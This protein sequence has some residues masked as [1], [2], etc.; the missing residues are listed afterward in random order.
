MGGEREA[1]E[2]LSGVTLARRS[3]AE[4]ESR[5]LSW[6]SAGTYNWGF[7]RSPEP[8]T[9][10]EMTAVDLLALFSGWLEE[11]NAEVSSSENHY[12]KLAPVAMAG[13]ALKNIRSHGA[14][15]SGQRTLAER[16][17][18]RC[19]HPLPSRGVE[20]QVRPSTPV[21][22]N[23]DVEAQNRREIK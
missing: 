3:G 8:D 5:S 12:L 20:D 15:R 18:R 14:V 9:S 21:F 11:G 1:K 19:F 23:W 10:P 22:I 13:S 6:V 4:A 17:G 7:E 2:E 16:A